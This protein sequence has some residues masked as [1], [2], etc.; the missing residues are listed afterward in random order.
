M[1]VGVTVT[2][3]S[4]SRRRG[5]ENHI[6]TRV[7]SRCMCGG[8]IGGGGSLAA[9]RLVLASKASSVRRMCGTNLFSLSVV[10]CYYNVL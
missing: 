1:C 8:G 10:E 5:L 9:H 7:V 4:S 3:Y 6:Y 2:A